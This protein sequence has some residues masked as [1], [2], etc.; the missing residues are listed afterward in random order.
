MKM[1]IHWIISGGGAQSNEDDFRPTSRRRISV[2]DVS[3]SDISGES[4]VL[5][6]IDSA[7]ALLEES[8]MSCYREYRNQNHL[9]MRRNWGNELAAEYIRQLGTPFLYSRDNIEGVN[10]VRSGMT[11]AEVELYRLSNPPPARPI[12]LVNLPEDVSD[13]EDANSVHEGDEEEGRTYYLCHLRTTTLTK[14]RD[15]GLILG[16]AC[17][18]ITHRLP[19][20]LT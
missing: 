19:L 7:A 2:E 15:L 17:F 10:L 20:D 11:V 12:P 6:I 18:P 9:H 13:G 16:I 4:S 3:N 5:T 8:R 14:T 1:G